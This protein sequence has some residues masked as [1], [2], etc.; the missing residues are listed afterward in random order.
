MATNAGVL[1]DIDGTLLDT[2]YLHVL[3]W[4]QAF[5]DNDHPVL[6][7]GIGRDELRGATARYDDPAALLAAL[8]SSPLADLR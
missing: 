7:G 2:N 3:A 4:W 6:S 5:R 8:D 1:F